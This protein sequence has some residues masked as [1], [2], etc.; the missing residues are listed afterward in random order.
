MRPFRA[1][2]RCAGIRQNRSASPD[3]HDTSARRR[4]SG[5]RPGAG[6]RQLQN[7]AEGFVTRSDH[8]TAIIAGIDTGGTF[9]DLVAMVDGELVVHKTLST[10]DDPARAVIEC[11][12]R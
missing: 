5:A 6:F 12:A 1:G 11:L 7:H 4:T 9:T 2:D 8:H 10:P 3:F